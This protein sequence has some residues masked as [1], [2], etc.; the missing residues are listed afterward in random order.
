M[1]IIKAINS[2][3]KNTTALKNV[4]AYVMRS[5]KTKTEL[6]Y[7][8]GAWNDNIAVTND[9]VYKAFKEEKDFWNKNKGRMYAHNVI[10][11]APDE[12]I[13]PTEV[14]EFAKEWTGKVYHGF[15]SLIAVHTDTD[16]LH[17][18]VITNSVSYIDGHKL[19]ATKLD[20]ARAKKLC[21]EMCKE[22]GFDVTQKGKHFDGKEADVGEIRTWNKN[23]YKAIAYADKQSYLAECAETVL[24]ACMAARCMEQFN[25]IMF[26]NGWKEKNRKNCSYPTFEDNA[27]HKINGRNLEKSFN[28]HC[29]ADD[30]TVCFEKNMQKEFEE[31]S[32]NATKKREPEL[33]T[34][35]F[36]ELS[37][38]R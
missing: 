15:N 22:R 16:H 38:E 20:L 19:H 28:I 12:Q 11:F 18:H 1:A 9:S 25:K 8:F 31:I 32:V 34:Y 30:L 2:R 10:S 4:L 5:D 27:G 24:G 7:V 23:K 6:T 14:L 29:S 35:E 3:S 13:T 21:N 36:E 37:A 26:R 33:N 17:C